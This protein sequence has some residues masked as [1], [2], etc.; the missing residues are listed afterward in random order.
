MKMSDRRTFAV[1]VVGLLIV[2]ACGGA[3][4]PDVK[5][6]HF[7]FLLD[8]GK[9]KDALAFALETY[10][11]LEGEWREKFIT[12]ASRMFLQLY[13][14]T[15]KVGYRDETRKLLKIMVEE[16]SGGSYPY[17]MM[18]SLHEF[19]R[20]PDVAEKWLWKA[21]KMEKDPAKQAQYLDRII[22]INKNQNRI[23][24]AVKICDLMRKTHPDYPEMDRI[25]LLRKNLI[26][27]MGRRGMR[28][29]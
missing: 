9:T 26:N 5:Y 1:A 18:A 2:S 4:S 25:L 17:A 29:N 20:N 6:N 24:R 14:K 23:G 7:R 8:R 13:F 16:K 28:S 27:E 15:K 10:P 12:E 11:V 3:G 22:Q 21:R 19:E